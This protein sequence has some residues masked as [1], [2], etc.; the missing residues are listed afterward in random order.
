MRLLYSL[1]SGWLLLS[2]SSHAQTAGKGTFDKMIERSIKALSC[3]APD[4]RQPVT[5][6][7]ALVKLAADGD[8]AVIIKA[9]MA[10]GWHLYAYVPSNLPYIPTECLLELSADVKAIGGWQK[11]R[12]IPSGTDRGVLLWEREAVF[13]QRLRLGKNSEGRVKAGLSYQACDFRQCLPPA[14][15]WF[16]LIF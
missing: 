13:V 4:E 8:M 2:F 11:S 6:N 14:D 7:T 16:D 12:A 10:A 5:I 3:P 9:R 15:K 1:L